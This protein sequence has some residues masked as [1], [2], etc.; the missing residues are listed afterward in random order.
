M[1]RL[2]CFAALLV[3]R[4]APPAHGQRS[5]GA[6]LPFVSIDS[7]H[8]TTVFMWGGVSKIRIVW[9]DALAMAG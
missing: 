5:I 7:A 1:V 4:W 6:S 9:G 2:L 3:S 8:E